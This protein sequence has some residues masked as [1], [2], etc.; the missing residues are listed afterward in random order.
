[1]ERGLSCFL[2]LAVGSPSWL[3]FLGEDV[4]SSA[5]TRSCREEERAAGGGICEGGA[6]GKGGR[7]AVIKM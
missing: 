2:C 4:S 7:E 3:G 1:M 5:G 6:G